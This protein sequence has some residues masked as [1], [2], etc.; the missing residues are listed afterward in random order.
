MLKQPKKCKWS[1]EKKEF[2]RKRMF[3]ARNEKVKVWRMS[4]EDEANEL[5][6][7]WRSDES[8]DLPEI[9]ALTNSPTI[10]RVLTKL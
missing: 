3:W 9:E 2:W 5:I 8:S 4:G 7:S 10:I 1:I 6:W